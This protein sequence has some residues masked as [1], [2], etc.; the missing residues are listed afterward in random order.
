MVAL[1]TPMSATG[2]LDMPALDRL[3]DFHLHAGT[4]A[5]VI[6]GTTGESATLGHD[7]YLALLAHAIDQVSGRLLVIAGAGSCA[8]AVAIRQA[9][10]A[11]QLGADGLLVVTP[12]YNRP[13][14]NGLHDHY[15]A[16][17]E[18]SDLPVVLYNVPSRTSC[19][20]LPETVAKLAE[21]DNIVAIKEAVAELSRVRE[22]IDCTPDDF[23]VFSGDDATA[24]QSM[25]AGAAGVV[26]VVANLMPAEMAQLC[27]ACREK[28]GGEAERLNTRLEP[29]FAASMLESNPIPVKWCL[30]RMG[31]IGPGIRLPLTALAQR[32]RGSCE[33]L[34]QDEGLLA[35]TR[36]PNQSEK[37]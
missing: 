26:S 5:L 18:A 24:M 10:N 19:D 9:K 33:A 6:A 34:L 31:M 15:L 23:A 13:T 11:A 7:D 37:Q 16:V 2:V 22:L 12:Y 14:Q 35:R 8:T 29:F 25:Q 28:D 3:L 1:V 36:I 27:K 30:Y 20:M 4:D 32:Y 17:A 21:I